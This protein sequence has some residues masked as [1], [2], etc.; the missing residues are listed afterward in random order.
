MSYTNAYD[1]FDLINVATINNNSVTLNISTEQLYKL[2]T[3]ADSAEFGLNYNKSQPLRAIGGQTLAAAILRQLNQT[4]TSKGELKFSLLVG[5]YDT[6]LSFFGL[7]NLTA[8][9]PNFYGLPGYAST[10]AFELV[11]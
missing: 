8:A 11:T 2:R 1:I 10:M 6:F 3:L 9:D 7:T 4:I 5:S